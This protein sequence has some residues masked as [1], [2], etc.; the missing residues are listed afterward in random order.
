LIRTVAGS[1]NSGTG[2]QLQRVKFRSWRELPGCRSLR[3]LHHR[4][5]RISAALTFAT[6]DSCT[7]T[8]GSCKLLESGTYGTIEEL[9][10]VEKINP[11][12][13]SRILR[14]TLLAPSV[15]E[16]ILDVQ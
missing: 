16:L 15:V 14:M 5:A 11:S 1:R 10:A 12:Y 3:H 6:L 4:S 7:F 13:V 9:A 2:E 8:I